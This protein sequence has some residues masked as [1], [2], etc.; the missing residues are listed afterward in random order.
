M[1]LALFIVAGTFWI[2][3]EKLKDEVEMLKAYYYT[4]ESVHN[5]L[6]VGKPEPLVEIRPMEPLTEGE[7][8]TIHPQEYYDNLPAVEP[9]YD[10]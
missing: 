9:E 2:N 8:T 6:V 5:E 1:T 4:D 7:W 10:R 3:H